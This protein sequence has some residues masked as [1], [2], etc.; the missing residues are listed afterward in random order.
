VLSYENLLSN[1]YV[2]NGKLFAELFLKKSNEK[3]GGKKGIPK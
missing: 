1:I 2:K 3:K